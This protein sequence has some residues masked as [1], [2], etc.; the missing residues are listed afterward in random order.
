MKY[1]K[2]RSGC[3]WDKS[4]ALLLK[5]REESLCYLSSWRTRRARDEYQM[6]I[7]MAVLSTPRQYSLYWYTLKTH[8]KQASFF[9]LGALTFITCVLLR[10]TE[11]EGVGGG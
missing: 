2:G 5:W 11:N 3:L 9:C 4:K 6:T 10:Y 8:I 1:I 7:R